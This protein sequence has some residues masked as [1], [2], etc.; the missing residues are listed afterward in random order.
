MLQ[1]A[2]I[3]KFSLDA[4]TKK[5]INS[6]E[7]YRI[8]Q[9]KKYIINAKND[10]VFN[11]NLDPDFYAKYLQWVFAS[12]QIMR[13]NKSPKDEITKIINASLIPLFKTTKML[14]S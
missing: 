11:K 3:S 9:F 7:V 6:F 12:I 1:R 4:A 14:N 2:T 5:V 13:L 8:K 10:E